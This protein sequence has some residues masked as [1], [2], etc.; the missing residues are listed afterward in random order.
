M[1]IS[2]R[3]KRFWEI[4]AFI[5]ILSVTSVLRLSNLGSASFTYDAAFISNMAA[6]LVTTGR[7]PLQGMVS[8]VGVQN[9]ALA[10]YLL[11]L[12]IALQRDPRTTIAFIALLNA[13]AVGGV[14]WLGRRYWSVSVGC[15]AA[16]LFGVSPWAVHYSRQIWAQSLLPPVNVLLLALLLAWTV[17]RSKWALSAAI[18]VQ[19]ALMQLH[20][21]AIA[22]L[23]MI[24]I[25]LVV[26][27]LDA[28]RDRQPGRF[29]QP[30]AV[31]VGLSLL[32]YSPYLSAEAQNGWPNAQRVAQIAQAPSRIHLQ[33]FDQAL[34]LIGGRN[35]HSLAGAQRFQEYL[36]G[37]GDPTYRL[38][39]IEEGLFVLAILYLSGRVWRERRERAVFRSD[40]LLLL[41]VAS[42]VVF[43]LRSS[44]EIFVHYFVVLYPIPFLVLAIAATDIIDRIASGHLLKR[45]LQLVFGAA[46]ALLVIWQCSL[47][48]SIY[49]FVDTH[50]TPG[51]WGTP[52]RILSAVAANIERYAGNLRSNHVIILCA[53]AEPRWDECPAVFHY[54]TGRLSRL[55]SFMDYNDPGIWAHAADAETLVVLAPGAGATAAEL[56]QFAKAIPGAS[57]PLREGVDEYRFFAIHNHYQDV[58]K[59]IESANSPDGAIIL[60]GRNQDREFRQSYQ[61]SLPVYELPEPGRTADEAVTRLEQIADKHTQLFGLFRVAEDVDPAGVIAAW[62]SAHTYP[63]EDEWLGPI[64]SITYT[65]PKTEIQAWPKWQ[66]KAEFGDRLRLAEYSLSSLKATGGEALMLRLIWDIMTST[67]NGYT[68]FIH[69]LDEQG[70]VV[71]QRDVPLMRDGHASGSWRAGDRVESHIGLRVPSNAKP[72]EYRLIMGVYEPQTG[73]RLPIAGKDHLDAGTISVRDRP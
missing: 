5:G 73:Q 12:P 6:D 62:L 15:V 22:L 51:G 67:D 36:A 18:L 8:S 47:S 9:P 63:V 35:I 3:S 71:A 69:L 52:V 72:G 65:S 24:G 38:D 16:L 41:W 48:L 68:V 56:Q 37:L 23:P 20:F 14:C 28:Y 50:D 30:V 11:G 34:M 27:L 13:V 64:R 59:R 66:T 26:G 57:V 39:R 1:K 33:A 19:A 25:V 40:G 42:V 61:G 46:L 21:S 2:E 44:T 32:L 55:V 58:A 60:V 17:G 7:L 54:L 10:V 29:W 49:R 43:F 4:I 31:G 53:G 45:T 70:R